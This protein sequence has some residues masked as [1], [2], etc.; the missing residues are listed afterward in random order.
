MA[1]RAAGRSRRARLSVAGRGAESSVNGLSFLTSVI[2]PFLVAFVAWVLDRARKDRV[3]RLYFVSRDG[4]L[5]LKIARVLVTAREGPELCYLFGS[6]KSWLLP[7]FVP[8]DPA[9]Q[10]MVLDSG[11]QLTARSLL[12]K[13]G[14]EGSDSSRVLS[15]LGFP[16]DGLDDP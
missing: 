4:E 15:R 8:H 13:L 10:R 9:W 7:S 11:S 3:K 16:R 14:F 2:A 6:R 12:E 1:S 5:L